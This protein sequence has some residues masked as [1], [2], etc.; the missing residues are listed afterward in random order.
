MS[1]AKLSGGCGG[2]ASKVGIAGR[3]RVEPGRGRHGEMRTTRGRQTGKGR[4]PGGWAGMWGG[5]LEK[6]AQGKIA[7]FGG[8]EWGSMDRGL[9]DRLQV[10]GRSNSCRGAKVTT[11]AEGWRGG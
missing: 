10:H 3:I 4:R 11:G 5:T 1:G 2:S 7:G 6:W 9:R 8:E